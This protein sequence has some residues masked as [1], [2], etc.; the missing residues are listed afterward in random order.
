MASNLGTQATPASFGAPTAYPVGRDP[1]PLAVADFTGDR[2]LDVLVANT[3]SSSVASRRVALLRGD[4]T[5]ALS[6]PAFTPL[7]SAPTAM[8][9]G[10]LESD[11]DLDAFVLSDADGGQGLSVLRNTGSGG[12]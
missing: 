7:P 1:G 4:G 3:D 12:V 2:H 11:G 8:S 6:H 10:N 9:V 5:G